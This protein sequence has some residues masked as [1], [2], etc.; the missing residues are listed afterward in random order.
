MLDEDRSAALRVYAIWFNMFPG[1]SR[2]KWPGKLL[3]DGRVAHYWDAQQLVGNM[4]FQNLPTIW[5]KRAPQTGPPVDLIL[6][7]AYLLYEPKVRWEDAPPPVISWGSTI[8]QTQEQ[9][10]RDLRTLLR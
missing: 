7:D 3:T 10:V 1:D 5:E 6:W 8:I 4:Y 9:L 2:E